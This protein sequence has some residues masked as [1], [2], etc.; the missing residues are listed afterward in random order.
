ML[1]LAEQLLRLIDEGWT[2]ESDEKG[3]KSGWMRGLF[4]K[5]VT[6]SMSLYDS[7]A[8]MTRVREG[9]KPIKITT[10][11]WLSGVTNPSPSP[12]SSTSSSAASTWT[13]GEATEHLL[14]SLLSTHTHSV[15]A[16]DKSRYFAVLGALCSKQGRIAE[17]IKHYEQAI[18]LWKMD[19]EE[20]GAVMGSVEGDNKGNKTK[21]GMNSSGGSEGTSRINV[22]ALEAHI[23]QL[24]VGSYMLPLFCLS[25]VSL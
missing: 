8:L 24:Q 21:K 2:D 5:E 7:E 17:A 14:T 20:G 12:S 4:K 18:F 6:T 16:R 13:V 9:G 23:A 1:D 15:P 3:R 10:V 11:A 22:A 25:F 19:K